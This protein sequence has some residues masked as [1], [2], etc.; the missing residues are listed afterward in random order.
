M[1]RRGVRIVFVGQCRLEPFLHQLPARPLD[2]GDAGVESLGDLAVAPA[3]ASRGHIRL[4]EDAR[5]RQQAVDRLPERMSSESCS[6]S[7]ALSRTTYFLTPISVPATNH[8][9]R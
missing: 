5:L 8:L 4:Q 9:H 7:C 3:F 6:R 1:A 2:V